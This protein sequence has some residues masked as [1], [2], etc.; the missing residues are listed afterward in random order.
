MLTHTQES[1]T[2]RDQEQLLVDLMKQAEEVSPE[3][4]AKRARLLKVLQDSEAIPAGDARL[5]KDEATK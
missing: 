4:K 3:L 2:A 5:V 1:S